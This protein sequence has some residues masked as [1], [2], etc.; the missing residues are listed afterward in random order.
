VVAATWTIAPAYAQTTT[1]KMERKAERAADKVERAADKVED[2]A[3]DA[4]HFGHRDQSDRSI[5]ITP[6]GGS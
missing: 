6:I 2:K 3:T 5:V 4:A 1:D